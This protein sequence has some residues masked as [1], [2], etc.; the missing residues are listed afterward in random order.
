MSSM[1]ARTGAAMVA[2]LAVLTLASAQERMQRSRPAGPAA[3]Q[4]RLPTSGLRLLAAHPPANL[5]VEPQNPALQKVTWSDPGAGS[6]RVS[7][8]NP[9]ASNWTLVADQVSGTEYLDRVIVSLGTVYRVEAVYPT[10]M[11]AA[12]EFVY[13]NPLRPPAPEAFHS[14]QD[15]FEKVTLR[16]KHVA[17]ATG[18]RIFGPTMPPDGLPLD[19]S[20]SPGVANGGWEMVHELFRV[21]PGTHTFSIA[22][23][24]GS[25]GYSLDG[26]ASTTVTATARKGRYRFS[27]TGFRAIQATNDDPILHRD[28]KGDEIFV[29]A[30]VGSDLGGVG[31]IDRKIVRSRVY[32]D[33]NR[34]PDRIQAGSSSPHGGIGPGNAV[35]VTAGMP[36]APVAATPDRL[37]LLV[38]EGELWDGDRGLAIVPT[39][40]EF[41]GEK[42]NYEM[43]SGWLMGYR[44]DWH[45]VLTRDLRSDPIRIFS[46]GPKL[47]TNTFGV[48]IDDGFGNDLPIGYTHI[49]MV[50]LTTS[51][52]PS[53]SSKAFMMSRL[54]VEKTLGSNST[55]VLPMDWRTTGGV[56]G[57]YQLFLQVERLPRT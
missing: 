28:G 15:A 26:M 51:D 12:S 36:L 10:G 35:P 11:T 30:F 5:R 31:R 38:W 41:D 25:A 32:G 29:A 48:L 14:W 43:W 17:N 50:T 53:F 57:E 45:E 16:W 8:R 40:W 18:Y 6:F 46:I 52:R 54:N 20:S 47:D 55:A 21:P 33:V 19:V 13:Q 1:K 34:F 7:R 49:G 4:L 24:F 3:E 23:V 37:P 27:I 42:K 9:S 2:G 56:G 39:I 22:A 44:Y